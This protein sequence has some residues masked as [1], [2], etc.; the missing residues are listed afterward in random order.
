M[1]HI[2]NGEENTS[3]MLALHAVNRE[4]QLFNPASVEFV[5]YDWDTG[6]PVQVYPASGREDVSGEQSTTGIYPAKDVPMDTGL[7]PSTSWG[8]PNECKHTIK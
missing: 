2:A 7:I 8:S 1:P 4:G 5:V 3:E 6:A